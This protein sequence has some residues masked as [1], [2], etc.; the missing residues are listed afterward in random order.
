MAAEDIAGTAAVFQEMQAH[1]RVPCPSLRE[2]IA[3]LQ[4]LP[5]GVSI[6]VAAEPE[7]VGFAALSAIFPGPGLNPGFF[8]KELFVSAHA[9]GRRIGTALMRSAAGLAVERGFS[10]LDWTADRSDEGLLRFY[11]ALGAAEQAEKVFFRLSG[12][13]LT[14]VASPRSDDRDA[15]AAGVAHKSCGPST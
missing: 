6:L 12:P 9:R 10:R 15:Q 4:A 13:A 14:A 2:I 3:R 1:Y 8:L 11:T 5:D 7:I